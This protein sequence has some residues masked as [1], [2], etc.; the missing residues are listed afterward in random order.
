MIVKRMGRLCG[1]L[2]AAA[3]VLLILL[4]LASTAAADSLVVQPDGKIL[5]IGDVWPQAGAVARLDPDGTVDQS[6]GQE[7]FVIDRRLP[8]FQALAL[9]EDGRI[10]GGA[11]G[12]VQLVR[13]LPDGAPD[14]AFAGGGVGGTVEPDQPI[15]SLFSNGPNAIVP[16]PDGSIVVAE[17]FLL[18]GAGTRK[19]GSSATTQM[20]PSSKRQVT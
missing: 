6:F 16:R 20:A 17:N 5:L 2:G 13:Y 1:G 7:G 11:F 10:V 8:P 4:A 15:F 12:G 18:G 9:A 19:P 14:P 3:A